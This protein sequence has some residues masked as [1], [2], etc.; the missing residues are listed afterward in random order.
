MD[1][2]P[3]VYRGSICKNLDTEEDMDYWAQKISNPILR[4]QGKSAA[5]S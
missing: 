1:Q 2:S 5:Q 4:L 3:I